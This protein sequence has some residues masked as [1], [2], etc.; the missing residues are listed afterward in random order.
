M[1]GA[2]TGDIAATFRDPFPGTGLQAFW[3]NGG[4]TL[5][6][7]GGV[8]AGVILPNRMLKQFQQEQAAMERAGIEPRP[9][10]PGD[11]GFQAVIESNETIKWAVLEDDSLV[12]MP[13][14]V[15][16]T[17]VP[18]SFLSG[19]AGVK[20]AGEAQ[21]AYVPGA[22]PFGITINRLSGHFGTPVENLQVGVDAWAE[23]AAITFAEVDTVVPEG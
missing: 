15:N 6:G 7:S 19:G 12:I 23:Q 9:V 8:F 17:E 22:D 5:L 1:A 2:C 20:S 11:P 3:G 13:K 4:K 16:G 14:F 10:S 21:I 18:H